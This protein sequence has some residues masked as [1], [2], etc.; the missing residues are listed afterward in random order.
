MIYDSYVK[1]A[2]KNIKKKLKEDGL[3]YRNNL[4][5]VNY[6]PKNPFSS[7]YYRPELETSMECIEYQV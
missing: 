2:I 3:E 6:F 5:D 7:V 4:S 1:E